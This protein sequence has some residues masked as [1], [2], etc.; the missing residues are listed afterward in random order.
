MDVTSVWVGAFL[1]VIPEGRL[2]LS[3]VSWRFVF[4]RSLE[5]EPLTGSS[6]RFSSIAAIP[7]CLSRDKPGPKTNKA[8]KV[9]NTNRWIMKKK[10]MKCTGEALKAEGP[11]P[12]TFQAAK[13]LPRLKTTINLLPFRWYKT[14]FPLEWIAYCRD[15]VAAPS[16][17]KML[18]TLNAFAFYFTKP[19][20]NLIKI[21]IKYLYLIKY[22]LYH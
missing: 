10:G 9:L 3:P 11:K 2:I 16:L 1:S 13:P 4:C 5:Q 20:T 15:K 12:K 7:L 6:W 14:D 18:D 22:W 8:K 19:H 21:N 17:Q